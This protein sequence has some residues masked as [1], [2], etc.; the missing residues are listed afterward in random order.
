MLFM[1]T[2]SS[3]Y[4]ILSSRYTDL[5]I[6]IALLS[7]AINILIM[8][9]GQGEGADPLPQALILTAIVIGFALVAFLA[10]YILFEVLRHKNDSIPTYTEED[11]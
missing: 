6:G 2:A 11:V 4:L 8:E 10:S 1:M 9:M 5:L 7:N 3:V